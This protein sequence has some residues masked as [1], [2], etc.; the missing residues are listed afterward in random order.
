MAAKKTALVK[1]EDRKTAPVKREERTRT[2]ARKRAVPRKRARNKA[3][4]E[5]L[6]MTKEEKAM[7]GQM[8]S[9]LTQLGGATAGA[10]AMALGTTRLGWDPE[11]VGSGLALAGSVLAMQSQGWLQCCRAGWLMASRSSSVMAIG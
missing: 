8:N 7:A 4:D 6:E 9:T 10:V 2:P 5:P 3:A 1:R 11:R